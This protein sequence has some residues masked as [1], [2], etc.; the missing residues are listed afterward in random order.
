M[1]FINQ[2]TAKLIDEILF[3]SFY[4]IQLIEL[5]GLSVAQSLCNHLQNGQRVLVVAGP[6]NN[7]NDA[8]VAA[9]HLSHFG[10]KVELLIAQKNTNEIQSKLLQQLQNLNVKESK[11]VEDHDIILDGL[12]GFGFSGKVREE[13][14]EIY[15]LLVNESSK[16]FSIDIP[17][18]WEC[19]RA[20]NW[21]P[22]GVC[23]L[24]LPKIC[25]KNFNGFHYLGGRFLDLKVLEDLKLQPFN[26]N[27]NDQFM[28]L[29]K[30]CNLTNQ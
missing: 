3:S 6:G 20:G 12:F 13:Y 23:S 8:L 28:I 4:P 24:S 2:K 22:F 27:S 7:G 30:P 10:Y 1:S 21:S 29:N 15:N 11:S 16:V 14:S 5:A 25:M 18:G 26:Y 9:R 17:S 19:E